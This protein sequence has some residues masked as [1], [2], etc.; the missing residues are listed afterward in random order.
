MDLAQEASDADYSATFHKVRSTL[1]GANLR[2]LDFVRSL[3]P[4]YRKVLLDIA[5]GHAMLVVAM[6]AVV[7]L[8]ALGV[9]PLV[10]SLIGAILVGY[11]I[12]LS[13]ALPP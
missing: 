9:H 3:R 10:A 6:L 2:Y 5:L 12:R 1:T 11:W 13:S 7:A 4:N 8:A